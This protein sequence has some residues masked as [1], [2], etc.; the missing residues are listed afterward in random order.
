[1]LVLL[2]N[3]RLTPLMLVFF[4]ADTTTKP[5]YAGADYHDLQDCFRSQSRYSNIVA[6]TN[7]EWY[8]WIIGEARPTFFLTE[9]NH[10]IWQAEV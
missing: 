3:S 8:A 6:S 10:L 1:M 4:R 5:E 9:F 7:F 2:N